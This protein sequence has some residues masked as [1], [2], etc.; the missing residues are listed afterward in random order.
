M[1]KTFNSQPAFTWQQNNENHSLHCGSIFLAELRYD[2]RENGYEYYRIIHAAFP[3]ALAEE[4]YGGWNGQPL[5]VK[6]KSFAE[7]ANWVE[8]CYI[9]VFDKLDF[10]LT[11]E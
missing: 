10:T 11:L 9:A 4:G 2:G 1:Q 6:G 3:D 5:D 8:H 7:I